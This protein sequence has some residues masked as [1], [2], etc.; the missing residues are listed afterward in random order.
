MDHCNTNEEK[1]KRD[2]RRRDAI[3]LFWDFPPPSE[4]TYHENS[5]L[6]LLSNTRYLPCQRGPAVL[7]VVATVAVVHWLRDTGQPR[8]RQGDFPRQACLLA[9]THNQKNQTGCTPPPYFYVLAFIGPNQGLTSVRPYRK[10]EQI[11]VLRRIL[12]F[13]QHFS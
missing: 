4:T 8:W 5:Y 10:V 9:C 7:P 13:M 2:N 11:L 6:V 1:E 3:F 12:C